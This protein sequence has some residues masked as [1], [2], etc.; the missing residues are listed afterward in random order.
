MDPQNQSRDDILRDFVERRMGDLDRRRDQN[1]TFK[2]EAIEKLL[3]QS[4]TTKAEA[5]SLAI[6]RIQSDRKE[7]SVR[8][9][10]QV[11]RFYDLIDSLKEKDTIKQM[12]VEAINKELVQLKAGIG[13][14]NILAEDLDVRIEKM[15]ID[16]INT[17]N[18]I[19]NQGKDIERIPLKMIAIT[20]TVVVTVLKIVYE[21]GYK[22]LQIA[23]KSVVSV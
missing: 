8:C 5:L 22:L 13:D 19:L 17:K 14:A 7:C 18:L 10:E 16:L 21:V 9:T 4:I 2:L 1:L 20:S 11:K 15:E 3:N 6:T 23:M 12:V